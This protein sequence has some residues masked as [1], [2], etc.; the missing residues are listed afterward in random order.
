MGGKSQ[1]APDYGP[2]AAASERAAEL[3]YELGQE[4]LAFAKQQYGEMAPYAL[5]YLQQQAASSR[6]LT[7]QAEDYA[8]YMREF[9]PL[10]R[11]MLEGVSAPS[12]YD[13][14]R[15]RLED[16]AGTVTADPQQLYAQNRAL[17]EAQVGQAL[18]DTQGGFSRTL[19][20]IGR[21]GLR[22]GLSPEAIANQAGQV[23]LQQASTQASMANQA[24]QAALQDIRGRAQQ[25][26]GLTQS[27]EQAIQAQRSLDFA[28]QMDIA[29]LGRGLVGASQGAY[30][31]AGTAGM[32]GIQG[33]MAP[34]QQYMAG[35]GQGAGTIMAGQQQQ[36]GGLS[37]IL[38]AQTSVYNANQQSGL[39]VGGLLSGGAALM[40]AWPSDS[41]L[42][43]NI[44]WVGRDDRTGI[45]LY[46]FNYIGEPDHRY[47]GVMAQDVEQTIPEAVS[48]GDNGY[49]M[50]NYDMIGIDM[51]EVPNGN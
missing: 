1:K 22:Y 17:V 23:G 26:Y 50:V 47:R 15:Q 9:R 12:D 5:E 14:Y 36:L 42:K 38:S 32:Q 6:A 2:M 45:P 7:G 21:Q 37:N 35:M 34:G 13:A 25:G 4:Q 3:G 46:E 11:Q 10:E 16:Y 18:A 33:G 43:E 30:G 48:M 44:E 28:R 19:G 8:A 40:G 39:D 41:R 20:Q 49:K 27:T 29:G 51:V 24:R 31:A